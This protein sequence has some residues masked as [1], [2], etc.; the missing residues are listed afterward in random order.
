MDK[1]SILVNISCYSVHLITIGCLPEQKRLSF[2]FLLYKIR[3][4]IAATR[5]IGVIN[6]SKPKSVKSCNH[7]VP[8]WTISH[9]SVTTALF[10]RTWRTRA[11]AEQGRK[12]KDVKMC[13]WKTLGEI[14]FGMRA[15]EI[16]FLYVHWLS[17]HLLVWMDCYSVQLMGLKS[18]QHAL[19]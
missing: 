17:K 2:F 19:K 11:L 13:Y 6:R 18:A 4:F 3:M 15:P 9:Q 14:Q 16:S 7:F 5:L 1:N 12:Q 10:Q 8:V